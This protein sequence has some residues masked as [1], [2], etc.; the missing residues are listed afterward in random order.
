[1]M[2]Q[3]GKGYTFHRYFADPYSRIL[4]STKGHEFDAVEALVNS[5]VSIE[6]AVHQVAQHTFD[7]AA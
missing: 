7:E 3:Y 2:V 4:F 5:G 6:Q 1:M